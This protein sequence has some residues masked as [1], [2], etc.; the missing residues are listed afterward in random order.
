MEGDAAKGR[1]RD[2]PSMCSVS[3]GNSAEVICACWQA[4]RAAEHRAVHATQLALAARVCVLIICVVF[5]V[6]GVDG[7]GW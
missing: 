7:G 3:H 1:A 2:E 4:V 6:L 5:L